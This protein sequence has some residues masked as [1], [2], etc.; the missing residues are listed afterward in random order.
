MFTQFYLRIPTDYDLPFVNIEDEYDI[1]KTIAEGFFAK[2]F[3]TYHKPTKSSIVLKACH[4]ELTTS[5]EFI[6]EFH[7][8][9]QLSH[10][11][12]I[13]SCYQV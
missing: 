8:N 7:Y 13:L 3:L 10:H 11:H 12:N 6:K 5:K 4:T 9:Y 2:I 1:E